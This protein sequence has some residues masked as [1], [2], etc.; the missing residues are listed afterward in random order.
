[1]TNKG[2][3][4]VFAGAGLVI[5]RTTILSGI[6]LAIEPGTIHCIIGPNGGGKSSLIRT[7]LGQMR[8]TGQVSIDWPDENRTIGYVPQVVAIDKTMPMT[9][10]DFITLCVQNR[11]AF[12]GLRKNLTAVVSGILSELGMEK[13]RKFLFSELSGGERQR[14]L[15]AQA[16]IPKPRLLILD[17][18][19]NSID[20]S[21][22]LIFAEKIRSI[23]A[24]GTTVL[25]VHHDLAQVR[26]IA[27]TVTCVN[28]RILFSGAPAEVMDEKHLFEIYSSTSE[29]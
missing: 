5:G 13:K 2:P 10:A 6:D 7:M 15:F 22:S 4:I 26:A 24:E 21:G 19:M 14:V 17:E 16:L 29:E 11:P 25:W 28:R 3:R 18:P 1:M 9:V 23:A 27:D 20:R 12:L 8:H